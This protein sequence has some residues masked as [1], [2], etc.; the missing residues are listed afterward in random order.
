MYSVV[1]PPLMV[2]ANTGNEQMVLNDIKK[3]SIK[4]GCGQNSGLL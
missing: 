3:A 1:V 4:R 2:F